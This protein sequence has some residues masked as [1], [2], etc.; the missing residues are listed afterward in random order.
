MSD[1]TPVIQPK[2]DQLNS[3]SLLAGPLTIT[4]T[5]VDINPTA[6]QP[7]AIH[8]E[9]EDGKPWKPCK[10]MA[11][12]L[13]TAWGPDAKKYVGRS[14]TLY[15]DP[16]VKWA[17][18]E[19]GG[20]RVSHMSHIDGPKQM[21]LTATRGSRKPH[22]VLPLGDVPQQ[23]SSTDYNGILDELRAIAV[24]GNMDT[25]EEKWR[26]IGADAR[27]HLAGQ[28]AD[29]KERCR[30]KQDDDD[31]AFDAPSNGGTGYDGV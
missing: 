15:R 30:P 17:G 22:K 29:L 23:R 3:D 9:G 13:V 31:V 4:I 10:S 27:K 21:M 16:T 14:V 12:C 20:I 11:R 18:L 5:K 2:S 7:V 25:L 6:E 1:M 26:G 19:V 8:Y 24:P 28:L